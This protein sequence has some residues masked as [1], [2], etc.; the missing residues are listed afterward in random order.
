LSVRTLPGTTGPQRLMGVEQQKS[1][2]KKKS[3][4]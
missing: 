3:K 4:G 1:K 2:K